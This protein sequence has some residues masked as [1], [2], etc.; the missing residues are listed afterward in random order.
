MVS[1]SLD[2]AVADTHVDGLLVSDEVE[3]NQSLLHLYYNPITI[4]GMMVYLA[5]IL[6]Y[7]AVYIT[8]RSLK[9]Q[10]HNAKDKTNCV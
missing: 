3:E 7:Y 8:K 2:H 1:Q 9:K 4:A 10:I 5:Y 6:L